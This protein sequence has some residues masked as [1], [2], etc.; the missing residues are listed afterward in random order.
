MQLSN[1]IEKRNLNQNMEWSLEALS[2]D[3]SFA[4]ECLDNMR[5]GEHSSGESWYNEP[6]ARTDVIDGIIVI[7]QV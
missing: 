7:D 4:Q 6:G 1:A 3:K 5:L 2:L